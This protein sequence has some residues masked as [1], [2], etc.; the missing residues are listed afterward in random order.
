MMLEHEIGGR[1]RAEADGA[2]RCRKAHPMEIA[3]LRYRVMVADTGSL[4]GA[5]VRLRLNVPT[6]SRRVAALEDAPGLTLLE[7]S[8]GGIKLMSGGSKVLVEIRK[9]AADLASVI[10]AARSN[11]AGKVGEIRVGVTGKPP[12]RFA[13]VPKARNRRW[14]HCARRFET[15]DGRPPQPTNGS[16]S[17]SLTHQDLSTPRPDGNG[18]RAEG[19]DRGIGGLTSGSRSAEAGLDSSGCRLR[20]RRRRSHRRQQCG[21]WWSWTYA[22]I[23][24][25]RRR[26]DGC[27]GWKG[28]PVAGAAP[29]RTTPRPDGSSR[30]CEV[31]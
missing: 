29:V 8:R 26:R 18:P 4:A 28:N 25:R 5:A 9:M 14:R 2:S 30:L 10:Q 13:V 24:G 6:L 22:F 27:G 3:S 16:P 19:S 23:A 12:R 20:D 31:A 1:I 15:R 7:R 11:G 21:R 17:G